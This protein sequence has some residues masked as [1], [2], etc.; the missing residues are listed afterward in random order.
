MTLLHSESLP[1]GWEAPDFKLL[2]ID[3]KQYSLADFQN[4]K[5]LLV[6]FTCNHCPYAQA[7]WP[8]TL[9]L[10][11]KYGEQVDFVA[12]NSN[13]SDN[14][15]E[16]SYAN[17]QELAQ[18]MQLSFP[19]LHDETQTIAKAYQAQCTPDIYLFELKG[20]KFKLYYHGRINDNWQE[21]EKVTENSLAEALQG[22]IAGE[23]AP[24][25][26]APSMGCSIKWK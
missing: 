18:E 12:I 11:Q 20:G 9:N 19:Y 13:E 4:K 1:L 21:P 15:P 16:D 22:L 2:G 17:M 25:E 8:L 23:T 10:Y 14:Y 26:S 24:A 5:G 7:A 3:E 6:I